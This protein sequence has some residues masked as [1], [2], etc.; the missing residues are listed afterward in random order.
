[1]DA[2]SQLSIFLDNVIREAVLLETLLLP[3]PHSFPSSADGSSSFSIISLV[4]MCSS[5]P[6]C[7]VTQ[8]LSYAS[9]SKIKPSFLLLV[10]NFS[11]LFFPS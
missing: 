9:L 10:R 3:L 4:T 11:L 1:M 5:T 8:W 6:I 7:P 2:Y